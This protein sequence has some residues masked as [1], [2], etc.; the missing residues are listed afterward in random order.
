MEVKMDNYKGVLIEDMEMLAETESDFDIQL[1][2]TIDKWKQDGVR[3]VR[4]LFKPPKCHL[5]NVAYK[6][7]FYFHHAH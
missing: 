4:I 3:S 2:D 7:G 5:M 6:H 1:K